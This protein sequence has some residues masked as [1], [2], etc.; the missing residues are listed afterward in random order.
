LAQQVIA[1]LELRKFASQFAQTV[2]SD[3]DQSFHSQALHLKVLADLCLSE[4]NKGN[5]EKV[6]EIL[7]KISHNSPDDFKHVSEL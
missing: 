1:Q 5:L 2:P 4:F 6:Q 7:N 3:N